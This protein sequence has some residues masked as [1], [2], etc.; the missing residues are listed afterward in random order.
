MGKLLGGGVLL[1]ALVIAY[2]LFR[3][4]TETVAGES[5]YDGVHLCSPS[6]RE[7]DRLLRG[8]PTPLPQ[9]TPVPAT[10][11]E[12]TGS[13]A[14]F[15]Q[16]DPTW[17]AQE[18]DHG[19][20]QDVG[21]GTTIAECGCA[22]TSV[23]TVLSLFQVLSTPDG[24][25]L[26]PSTLNAWFNGGAKLTN[27]GWASQG[28]IYGN[29]VWS[30]VNNFKST[31][32]EQPG[33]TPTTVRF[34]GWGNGSEAEIRAELSRGR[35]VV[36]EVPGHYIAAVGLQGND[37]IINDPYYK[38]R[39]TL[40]SYAGR[41]KS[42]RKYEPSS[43]LR[44]IMLSVPGGTRVQI[45]DMQGRVVGTLATG[46]PSEAAAGAKRDIP[47]SSYQFEEQWRDPTCTERPPRDGAG[48]N[49]I[50]IPFPESGRYQVRAV[51]QEGNQTSVAVYTYDV[52]G[53]AT[54]NTHEGGKDLSFDFEYNSG[55]STTT[56]TPTPTPTGTPAATPTIAATAP[57]NAAPTLPAP[58]QPPAPTTVPPTTAPVPPTATAVPPTSTPVPPTPTPTFGPV[59]RFN[60]TPS[61]DTI[62]CNGANQTTIDVTAVDA[63]GRT[64]PLNNI[65]VVISAPGSHFPNV[66]APMTNGRASGR[67]T[68][69]G[70]AGATPVNVRFVNQP[71]GPSGDT[72]FT[73]IFQLN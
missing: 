57:A 46:A 72:T 7:A 52:N 47:G 67:I 70:H 30:A 22:M 59:T 14:L 36:L 53:S 34:A 8:N 26:S 12:S 49:T 35:P 63:S 13:L 18:Y 24:N 42:S 25:G 11:G 5:K 40:A 2:F 19:R 31:A 33:G 73:C 39:T 10:G 23:A 69:V 48:V 64:V 15:A 9:Q 71:N 41:V 43:D 56:S 6:Q 21:C 50:F 3:G 51:N 54:M 45:T 38:D 29:V 60:V 32:A 28:Y 61:P 17:G 65:S 1:A 55:A 27:A 44:A 68:P 37:I 4:D 62:T 20:Q 58:T 16:N 66:T